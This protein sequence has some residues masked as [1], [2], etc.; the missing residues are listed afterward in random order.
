MI[1]ILSLLLLLSLSLSV[2]ITPSQVYYGSEESFHL[3]IEDP[4]IVTSLAFELTCFS[5]SCDI[6]SIY[7]DEAMTTPVTVSASSARRKTI[8]TISSDF[9]A[10]YYFKSTCI[11]DCY[12]ELVALVNKPGRVIQ[13][14][15]TNVEG[16]TKD[17]KQVTFTIP[18]VQPT[19]NSTPLILS[20]NALNCLTEVAIGE[21]KYSNKKHFQYQVDDTTVDFAFTIQ[22]EAMDD[23]NEKSEVCS[24]LIDAVEDNPDEKFFTLTEGASQQFELNEATERINLQYVNVNGPASFDIDY[25]SLDGLE[26]SIYK[27]DMTTPIKTATIYKKKTFMIDSTELNNVIISIKKKESGTETVIFSVI[28]KSN[29]GYPTY[30]QREKVV[31]GYLFPQQTSYY[32][33]DIKMNEPGKLILNYRQGGGKICVRVMPKGEID[34][35]ANWMHNVDLSQGCLKEQVDITG[36]ITLVQLHNADTEKCENGC[37]LIVTVTNQE[38]A[39]GDAKNYLDEFTI[40][41]NVR[42]SEKKLEVPL[43]ENINGEQEKINIEDQLAQVHIPYDTN[44]L[45]ISYDSLL[46]RMYLNK[47]KE[48]YPTEDD[49]EYEYIENGNYAINSESSLKGKTLKVH[50]TSRDAPQDESFYYFKVSPQY[51]NTPDIIYTT[52]GKIDK[53]KINKDGDSCYFLVPIKDYEFLS[54]ISI[55]GFTEQK[56]PVT[57]LAKLYPAETIDAIKYTVDGM[58]DLLPTEETADVKGDNYVVIPSDKITKDTDM[59][60][61]V[62]ATSA[63]KGEINF[64]VSSNQNSKKPFLYYQTNPKMIVVPKGETYSFDVYMR[65][66]EQKVEVFELYGK[67]K[68]EKGDSGLITVTLTA[69]EDQDY[70]VV[71]RW[72]KKL[73]QSL[74]RKEY[75]KLNTFTITTLPY[76]T[77]VPLD[78]A[79]VSSK[80]DVNIKIKFF[81]IKLNQEKADSS[82]FKV[83]ATLVDSQSIKEFEYDT[84]KKPVAL[85]QFY[86]FNNEKVATFKKTT[87]GDSKRYLFI[88]IQLS[89]GNENDSE[90]SLNLLAVPITEKVPEVA[91]PQKEYYVDVLSTKD[92]V[93]RMIYKLSKSAET[94]NQ[95]LVNLGLI[96]QDNKFEYNV[97]TVKDTPTFKNETALIKEQSTFNGIST[98]L[99][100]ATDSVL[101]TVSAKTT[102]NDDQSIARIFIKYQSG[103]EGKLPTFQYNRNMNIVQSNTTCEFNITADNIIKGHEDIKSISYTFKV[104]NKSQIDDVSKIDNIFE[105]SDLP[106]TVKEEIM[107][108]DSKTENFF[109]QVNTTNFPKEMFF[110]LTASFDEYKFG[111]DLVNVTNTEETKDEG[112]DWWLLGIVFVAILVIGI[113]VAGI[114]FLYKKEQE[115]KLKQLSQLA[116]KE[117]L[118][119]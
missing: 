26:I 55:G 107:I 43:N 33:T 78:Q 96:D 87:E 50:F 90:V 42:E 20:I 34:E 10:N 47:D 14:G 48:T 44:R 86:Y 38:E 109:L 97:E 102:A 23:L 18:K 63:K 77:Y 21:E 62:K 69:S 41:Y 81:N 7:T 114:L 11:D 88:E 75:K 35:K 66:P 36:Y 106:E 56:D 5:G 6:P 31:Y 113:I 30:F 29:K 85:E 91:L 82:S 103:E 52:S 104:Y 105:E 116:K 100:T 45:L 3:T 59:Y 76:Y 46:F 57:L 15:F 54:T 19:E 37:E 108:L 28:F 39:K 74:E 58:K 1:N 79:T 119:P 4:T 32:Y 65:R 99:L 98:L 61:L 89:Q 60:I 83:F 24:I 64:G 40:Y 2:D 115:K 94:D 25:T 49:Y 95:I 118:L 27:K 8:L 110:T 70:V 71:I 111:Y 117:D 92:T 53:C 68:V 93:N 80:Q 72:E 16:I 12:F 51:Q 17:D 112:F 9:V 73:G 67:G 22:V 101:L 13:K 84:A